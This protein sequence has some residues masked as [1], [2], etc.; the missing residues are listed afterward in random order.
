MMIAQKGT[1]SPFAGT[2]SLSHPGKGASLK[3]RS[4][5]YL[6]DVV[7]EYGKHTGKIAKD[8]AAYKE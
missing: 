5:V 1:L 2:R 6:R 7:T 4:V 8:T 3:G